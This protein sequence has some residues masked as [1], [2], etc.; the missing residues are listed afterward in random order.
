MSKRVARTLASFCSVFLF[1]F[2]LAIPVAS[3][4]RSRASSELH[5][6][7]AHTSRVHTSE[8]H[9]GLW[10]GRVV[11][12]T[13]ENGRAISEGDII[14][15]QV[16]PLPDA[17]AIPNSV[18]VAYASYLWPKVDGVAT[19]YYQINSSSGDQ[20]NIGAAI[21]QF[22]LDFPGLIQWVAWNP[23]APQSP[24]YVEI[25]LNG[26]ATGVCEAE[27]GYQPK[28]TQP[29]PMGGASNCAVGTILHEM[30]HVIGLWHEHERSD[31][32][33]Y[34]TVNYNNVIKGSWSN[35][36]LL[37]DNAQNLT[38]YDYASVMEYPPFSFSRN[39]GPVI[40]SIPPGI[41]MSGS[42][43]V[44]VPTTPDYSA[45]DKEGIERLY[46]TPPTSVT[47]TSNPP[48]LQVVVD[49]GSP[50]TTPQVYSWALNSTHT[51]SVPTNV[52]TLS[53]DI[54]N[55]TT[56]ATFYYTFGNWND[57]STQTH[58]ITVTPGNGDVGFPAT[59][60][61]V[62][63]YSANF[64]QI[65]P[66]TPSVYPVSPVPGTVAASPTPQSYSGE[67]GVFFVARQQAT[68]TATP[69]SGWNFYEFNN[70]PFWLPGGLGANPKTF[71]VPD[72]GLAVNT[73]VEFSNTPIYTLDI[74]PETFGSN[75]QVL[76]DENTGGYYS[77]TPKNFSSYYDSTW[78]P[79]S[80]HTVDISTLQ[81]PYSSN[82]RYAFSS[83]SDTGAQFHTITLPS[84]GGASYVATVTPE[85]APATNFSYPPCGGF[86]AISPSSPTGDGFYP[87]GQLLQYTAS[88]STGWTFAGWTFDLTGT[89][90]PDSLTA[91]DETLVFANFNITNV[92]LTLTSLSPN[93][94][95]SGST[96]FT[97]TLTGTGFATGSLV[98]VNGSNRT[99]LSVTP[100][101][102][103]V[104]VTSSDLATPT[105]FQVFVENYPSGWTGCAVFGSLPFFVSQGVGVPVVKPSPTTLTFK[106]KQA[107]GAT[108]ASQ[109]VTLKNT[110]SISASISI[111]PS[112]DFGETDNC[113]TLA[114]NASCTVNVTFT[115][116]IVGAVSGAITITDNAANSP[117]IVSLTGTGEAPITFAPTTLA[118]G[119]VAVGN[120]STKTLTI[121]NNQNKTLNF[122]YSAS[123]NYTAGGTGTTCGTSLTAGTKC[124]LA[125]TFT[126]LAKATINGVLT[127]TDDAAFSP[128]EVALTGK[129]ATGS[130]P[131]LKITPAS[132]SFTSQ[133]VGTAS[134]IKTVSVKNSS[135]SSLTISSVTASG[136]FTATGC[137]GALA[138]GAT[139]TLSLTFTPSISGSIKG[140]VTISD[141]ATIDQQ[142]FSVSGTAVLPVIMSPTS[143]TFSAQPVA[144][145]SAAQTITLTNNE[146]V[147]LTLNTL[148]AS[149]DFSAV[150]GGADPCGASVAAGATC[151]FNVTFTPSATGSIKGA[152]TV[153][154]SA[155]NSPQTL[156]LTGTGQN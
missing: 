16:D 29:Q 3:A 92:P 136:D 15:G 71:Y 90:N 111:K 94:A 12:Y 57:Q 121:T 24:T 89:T 6:G 56:L 81:K 123:G 8:V 105:N 154:D 76:W 70:G 115:P 34:V 153:T 62:A 7:E 147:A 55:S 112:G 11:N 17:G 50:V 59:S 41:P 28:F 82:S 131:L 134:A 86:G 66:Y 128:Q 22:N 93:T 126:P 127:I 140:A 85:F 48:G 40:E 69:N 113:S 149:G 38:L 9:T 49:E 4:H 39:G 133:A 130:A 68:L 45:A 54:A 141:N 84:S 43:G 35:F 1:S 109:S 10:H 114:I 137:T 23:E 117:Q 124:T 47:V 100:T 87:T 33:T 26:A 77:Y 150:P 83:W 101:T 118:F 37:G 110:G 20:T 106:T 96:G 102:I 88:P 53:G 155:S 103:T 99:P 138:A 63:T 135:A 52:Q 61:Q 156:K 108:S 80:S 51:L 145:T 27:E 116:T 98:S 32:N 95:P 139:C 120:S 97:L 64:V 67:S 31:R 79:N 73:T 104:P 36:E 18:G 151:T 91:N 30:G 44:P 13:I 146:N 14:L 129:S 58:M 5:T 148:A 142:V 42:E 72:T 75:L 122:T 78:T 2:F 25:N 65:V 74:T 152:V 144:T 143:L 60:P 19:V 119:T 46:G 21:T 107:V 132:V 125:V